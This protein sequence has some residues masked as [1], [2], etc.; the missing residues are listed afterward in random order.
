MYFCRN[1]T[2]PTANS[3]ATV[4]VM[5]YPRAQSWVRD[6]EYTNYN[7]WH[8]DFMVHN[9]KDKRHG[10][11]TDL[12]QENCTVAQE[13][14]WRPRLKASIDQ[15]SRD[16]VLFQIKTEYLSVIVLFGVLL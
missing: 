15:K 11:Y 2:F 12:N 9:I 1:L 3:N 5:I 14:L 10:P 8:G 7:W 16:Y 13:K 6:L 4:K